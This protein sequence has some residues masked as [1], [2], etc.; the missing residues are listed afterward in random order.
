MFKRTCRFTYPGSQESSPNAPFTFF[1]IHF[2]II[3]A[4]TRKPSK[5]RFFRLVLLVPYMAH[6]MHSRQFGHS[7]SCSQTT[8]FVRPLGF[9]Y[10]V[11]DPV[12]E[13]PEPL[14]SFLDVRDQVSFPC[15]ETGRIIVLYIWIFMFW[16]SMWKAKWF[17]TEH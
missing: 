2:N 13:I 1:Q 15:K 11:Q 3:P 4:S 9:K 10:S 12:I 7:K 6:T 8:S 14:L 17:W 16:C 5:W